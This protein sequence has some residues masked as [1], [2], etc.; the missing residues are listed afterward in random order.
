[1]QA[2]GTAEAYFHMVICSYYLFVFFDYCP[3]LFAVRCRVLK[4]HSLV[5]ITV[6]IA[7][8][9]SRCCSGFWATLRDFANRAPQTCP[10]GPARAGH[11]AGGGPDCVKI[12]CP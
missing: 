7:S 6:N 10:N 4:F 11:R 3:K 1:M 2:N 5:H 12:A 9:E 8:S